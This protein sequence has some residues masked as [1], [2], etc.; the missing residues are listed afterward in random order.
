MPIKEND[1]TLVSNVAHGTL[2]VII[3]Y[4]FSNI[5]YFLRT[6]VLIKL[7][8]PID[9]GLMGVATVV[10]DMFNRFTETGIGMALIQ[11]KEIN[12]T[13]LD[14]AWIIIFVRGIA[15]FILLYLFSPLVADFYNN[16]FLTNILKFISLSFLFNGIASIGIYLFVKELN[17]KDKAIFEQT[18]ALTN[19]IV[20]VILA[21]VFKNVW[22][23]AI[24][25][26]I[27][28]I[29]G[30]IFSYIL[31]P[32]RPSLNFSLKEAKGLFHFGK[33]VFASA[34]VTFF[35]MRGPDALVGK[36]LGLSF[37]GFY[38]AAS[39]IANIPA[40][41]ITH[42]ISQIAFPAYAK[43]QDDLSALRDGYLKITRL[44]AFLSAPIAG[45]IFMLIPEFVQIFLGT[46][47]MPIVVP[48]RILCIFGFFRSIYSAISPVLYGIGRPD[49]EFK[50]T[51]FN[52]VVT[53]VLIYPF[54]KG[55]GIIG[56]SIVFSLVGTMCMF[57]MARLVYKLI[58]LNETGLQFFK[59]IIFPLAA[60]SF[61]CYFIFLIKLLF[62]YNLSVSFIT[63]IIIGSG[64]YLLI[65]YLFNRYFNYGLGD[66]IRFAIISFKQR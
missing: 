6:L 14:T 61:M 66:T 31:Y 18:N 8:S 50:V 57:I 10:I 3:S 15:L 32:F 19:T 4:S 42:L 34:L 1:R 25:H 16:A 36:V 41:S 56:T 2:W 40:T 52:F 64:A 5:L 59:D 65:L 48:V 39:G 13:T 12:K 28:T 47:W 62:S 9:F 55:M 7:L 53:A 21:F 45:G 29:I 24:G 11:K 44:T 35:V 20:S 43:L 58:R 51:F 27:G 46:K 30:S 54:T 63:S 23:L 60:T 37:L 38:V 17:F 33:Y 49:L 26:I 22:A